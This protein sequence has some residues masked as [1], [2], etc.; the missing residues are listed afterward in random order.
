MK[1]KSYRSTQSRGASASR[2][3][4]SRRIGG[5]SSGRV[6]LKQG[7]LLPKQ[8]QWFA[9]ILKLRPLLGLEPRFKRPLGPRQSRQEKQDGE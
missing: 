8:K 7:M 3:K 2:R 5:S 1:Q 6:S 9:N 4:K